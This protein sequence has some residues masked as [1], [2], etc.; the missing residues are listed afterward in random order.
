[1]PIRQYFGRRS[2]ELNHLEYC[3][4]GQYFSVFLRNDSLW[5]DRNRFGPENDVFQ[6][7]QEALPAGLSNVGDSDSPIF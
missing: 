5:L 1:M 7:F 3:S 6:S 2:D 4:P